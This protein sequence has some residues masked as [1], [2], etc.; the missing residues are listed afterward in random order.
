MAGIDLNR[1]NFLS[2][3][4]KM[5]RTLRLKRPVSAVGIFKRGMEISEA[6]EVRP[7]SS[8]NNVASDFPGK[9]QF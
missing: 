3:S 8:M 2:L 4:E 7:P 1:T 9:S 5:K 6:K